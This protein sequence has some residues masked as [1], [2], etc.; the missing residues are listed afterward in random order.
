MDIVHKAKFDARYRIFDSI[1]IAD[2]EVSDQEIKHNKGISKKIW[3][4]LH[5][6]LWDK[7]T[8]LIR[9][10]LSFGLWGNQYNRARALITSSKITESVTTI[11]QFNQKIKSYNYEP[12]TATNMKQYKQAFNNKQLLIKKEKEIV[13]TE[14]DNFFSNLSDDPSG[15]DEYIKS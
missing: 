9:K 13:A 5:P 12:I 11:H 3:N 10:I 15:D 14:P 4:Q 1:G 8:C 7:V 2:K 6:S